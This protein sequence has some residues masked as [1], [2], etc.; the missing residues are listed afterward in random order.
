MKYTISYYYIQSNHL[1]AT[2]TY[3]HSEVVDTDSKKKLQTYIE[4]KKDQYGHNFKKDPFKGFGLDFQ[5]TSG[6]GAVK[7]EKYVKQAVKIKKI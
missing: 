4:S 7:V 6:A 5:Y 2:P 3:N 1:L